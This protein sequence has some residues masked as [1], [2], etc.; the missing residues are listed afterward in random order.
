M[1]E[2]NEDTCIIIRSSEN[3]ENAKSLVKIII[4]V[5]ILGNILF[6]GLSASSK[7]PSSS[8]LN[9]L[10]RLG[11]VDITADV[12]C[13]ILFN[14]LALIILTEIFITVKK[15]KRTYFRFTPEG[16]YCYAGS[17]TMLIRKDDIWNPEKYKIE[18]GWKY[19]LVKCVGEKDHIVY[20][21]T[22]ELHGAMEYIRKYYGVTIR[23]TADTP[24]PV[25]VH[26]I[27]IDVQ[28]IGDTTYYNPVV[29]RINGPDN[30]RIIPRFM[31]RELHKYSDFRYT[32]EEEAKKDL[33]GKQLTL[34][35]K[36]TEPNHLYAETELMPAK[37]PPTILVCTFLVFGWGIL[38][39][40]T[41]FVAK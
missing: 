29:K 23:E 18:I 3:I 39:L 14:V 11:N 22:E 12:I 24:R 17:H 25:L 8:I 1:Q 27:D 2:M 10:S 7:D 30:E 21:K 16:I 9:K 32:S 38:F 15:L 20:G 5:W 13:F 34:Y 31:G 6:V 35:A 33:V 36:E 41:F 37:T 26:V 40:V 19:I 4:F 28:D